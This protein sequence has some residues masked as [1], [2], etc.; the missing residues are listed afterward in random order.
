MDKLVKQKAEES[1]LKPC[2]IRRPNGTELKFI[3]KK[4]IMKSPEMKTISEISK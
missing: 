1:I 4:L 2:K 3:R